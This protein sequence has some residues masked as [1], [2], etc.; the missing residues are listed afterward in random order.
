MGSAVGIGDINHDGVG[1]LIIGD[2]GS[3]TTY[4]STY[5]IFGG[6]SLAGFD[7]NASPL[8]GSNGFQ[9]LCPYA[10]PVGN[11]PNGCGSSTRSGDINGDG[12]QDVIIGVQT[13]NVTGSNQEGYV[14][15]L[16]GKASGWPATYNLSTIY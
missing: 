7:V 4:G 2:P 15:V 10:N 1:D 16:F 5:V 14:Y 11:P 6:H 8:T 3:N 13:G 9:I 12:I